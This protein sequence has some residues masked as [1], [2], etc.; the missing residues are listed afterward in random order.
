MFI[1]YQI[2]DVLIEVK[3]LNGLINTA[4]IAHIGLDKESARVS[5]SLSVGS[6]LTFCFPNL[7]HAMVAYLA[8]IEALQCIG[9]NHEFI[10]LT[11]IPNF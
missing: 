8:F 1:K 9:T 2:T 11:V 7:D 10:K 5:I 3:T 4:H 6:D